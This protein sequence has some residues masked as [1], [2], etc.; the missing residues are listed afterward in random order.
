MAAHM[1]RGSFEAEPTDD[2]NAQI[3]AIRQGAANE[4]ERPFEDICRQRG[5]GN[6]LTS[7]PRP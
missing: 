3:A 1:D 7:L 2:G 4:S 5:R 6:G